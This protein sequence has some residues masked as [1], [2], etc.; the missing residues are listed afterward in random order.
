MKQRESMAGDEGGPVAIVVGRDQTGL[1][2]LRSLHAAGI[3]AV[4][5]CPAE[6]FLTRSRWYQPTPGTAPWDGDPGP[7]A[8]EY[9]RTMPV[10]RAVVIAG[11]DD[12]ALWAADLPAGP[13]ADRFLVCSSPRAV[14]ETLQDKARFG[15]FLE[16]TDMPHPRTF[17]IRSAADIGNIP[18]GELDR[19]FIKPVDSQ[20]FVKITGAKGIWVSDRAAFE[21]AWEKLEAQGLQVIAQE[22]IPG[23]ASDHYFI[24]G[25]RDR[26]GAL[27]GLFARRRMRIYPPHFGN[28]CYCVSI[29]L[30]EI[31]EARDRLVEL[32]ERLQYRGIFSAEFKR[33]A[34]D[35]K[36]RILEINTRAWW[37][38][39]FAT[40]C[41]VNVCRMAYEDALGLPV[42]RAPE[43]YPIG[44]G[45]THL[46]RDIR[47]VFARDGG[48]RVSAW[49][50]L[51]QWSRG[52]FS[53]FRLDD[54]MPG[55]VE[56]R[57]ELARALRHFFV[58]ASGPRD[59]DRIG[60]GN[61]TPGVA[62]GTEPPRG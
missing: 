46:A 25:F 21:K 50:A 14:L 11:R 61:T 35:G 29:P 60:S 6:S 22:Y 56:L 43:N 27:T 41:G 13:L 38:V 45:C 20:K 57:K 18:F 33:D 36:L 23:K 1:G 59:G 4:V 40:R 54:P 39:E 31:A 34:R 47:A 32:L 17:T 9:L 28:S 52:Y 5:A 26:R 24:D 62:K 58:G 42:T 8:H 15:E 3:R 19:V 10:E 7:G 30:G 37:Y 51:T 55:L 16:R 49:K 12:A 53:V 2:M 48:Q 44:A